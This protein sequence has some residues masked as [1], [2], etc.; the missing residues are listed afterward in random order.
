V[1][2]GPCEFHCPEANFHVWSEKPLHLKLHDWDGHLDVEGEFTTSAG[3][4]NVQ[5]RNG[6][7]D[8]NGL[9]LVVM[10]LGT[11]RRIEQRADDQL[12]KQGD[13][14]KLME[15][16]YAEARSGNLLPMAKWQLR[17]EPGRREAADPGVRREAIRE[18]RLDPTAAAKMTAEGIAIEHCRRE[19]YPRVL[20]TARI[21]T[22]RIDTTQ[23]EWAAEGVHESSFGRLISGPDGWAPAK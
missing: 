15:Y 16:I 9:E 2:T 13:P 22:K 14:Q 7:F 20:Q 1:L 10:D 17:S 11:L 23:V 21:K 4:V 3:P 8:L 19:E 6:K 12:L 18:L 5:T